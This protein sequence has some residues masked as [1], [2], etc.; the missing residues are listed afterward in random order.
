MIRVVAETGS[1]NADMLILAEK[2][3]REGF[4]LRAERQNQ[5]RGRMGRTWEQA[6]GNLYAS[7]IIRL[8]SFDPPAPGLALVAGVSVQYALAGLVSNASLRLKWPNDI[9]VG[10]AKLSGILLE[11]T[12]DA[13]IIGIGV[14]IAY[15]PNLTDR[16]TTCLADLGSVVD[17]AYAFEMIKRQLARWVQIWRS[18]GIAPICQ[19]WMERAHPP[20]TMMRAALPDGSICEGAFDSLDSAGN[21]NLRL[22]NGAISVIHAGDVFLI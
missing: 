10:R 12:G 8:G 19:A 17:A 4:W 14:N 5:G 22:A 9:M 3:E 18:S 2:G 11:R 20:G 6:D 7:T 16:D 15:A 21:L 13:V 1:T